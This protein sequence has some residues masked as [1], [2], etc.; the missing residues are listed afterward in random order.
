MSFLTLFY[1]ILLN[2]SETMLDISDGAASKD[3][4]LGYATLIV[5]VV[6]ALGGIYSPFNAT[7]AGL[8]FKILLAGI[9]GLLC[10]VFTGTVIATT[11]YVFGKNGRPQTILS[12]TALATMPWLFL[13]VAMLFKPLGSVG[14]GVAIIISLGLWAW[15][16]I[17]FLMAVKHTY[18]L[19]LERVLL[20]TSLP[21]LMTFLG[22]AWVSGFFI[23]LFKFLS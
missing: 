14:Y 12:L 21:I 2:P 16:T 18:H 7:A 4:L 6:S 15:S 10:W 5:L 19:T 17:L 9:S 1:N 8:P 3:R 22:I 20:A 23:N 13:P 11:A